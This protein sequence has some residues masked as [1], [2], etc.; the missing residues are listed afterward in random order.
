[1]PKKNN[2]STTKKIPDHLLKS[3]TEGVGDYWECLKCR[4]FMLT[5]KTALSHD[6][7]K[8]KP[9]TSIR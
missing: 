3:Y 2:K 8:C 5:L 4:H 7:K 6:V 9:K 1:M